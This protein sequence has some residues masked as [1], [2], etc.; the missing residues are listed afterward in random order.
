MKKALITGVAGQDGSYLAELLLEKGYHVFGMECASGAPDLSR[1]NPIQDRI[2]FVS[3][4]MR[5]QSSLDDVIR[6]T[7][8]DE[9]YNLA[10]ESFM[11]TS[12]DD[13]ARFGE[14]TGLGVARLM[15]A[16][17]HFKPD[18]RFCQASS[19]LIFG[20][21]SETPQTE[22]TPVSPVDPYGATKAYSHFMAGAY[23]ATERLFA[24]SAILFNHESPRRGPAF[25]TRKITQAAAKIKLG[26]A[27]EVT[28]GD[29][30]SQRDWGFA[31][32]YVEGMWLM[33]QQPA[34]DDYILATGVSHSVREWADVAFRSLGL[35]FENFLVSDSSLLRK[36]EARC[37]VGSPKKAER[38]LGW[39]PKVAFEELVKRMVEEDVRLLSLP[40]AN[41]G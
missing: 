25:V 39:R 4:D 30:D 8:P 41:P 20:N 7:L 17:S 14:V 37:L 1:L 21:P 34:P 22:A 3:G 33:L 16:L 2:H 6:Q 9:V 23:R 11:P 26:V 19:A 32:D 15:G 27:K 12:W 31:G 36:N 40:A 5:S 38:V 24:C 18:A 10:A 28:L 29:L 35:R 13:P